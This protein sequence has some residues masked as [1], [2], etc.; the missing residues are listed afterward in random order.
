MMLF[1][2]P[3]KFT[4]LIQDLSPQCRLTLEFTDPSLEVAYEVPGASV[5]VNALRCL[6]AVMAFA[7]MLSLFTASPALYN[8]YPA[9]R[10][11]IYFLALLVLVLLYSMEPHTRHTRLSGAQYFNV[12]AVLC[13][14]LQCFNLPVASFG[15]ASLFF[16]ALVPLLAPMKHA[17]NLQVIV[18]QVGAAACCHLHD[19]GLLACQLTQHSLLRVGIMCWDC[20]LGLCA[21]AQI[22]R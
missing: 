18:A 1:D 21:C 20:V 6:F 3:V 22:W 10:M 8:S 19:A 5:F 16:P 12:R 7:S 11:P 14:A 15:T 9:D 2:T 17:R 13:V 4:R